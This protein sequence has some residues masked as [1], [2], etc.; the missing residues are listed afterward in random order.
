MYASTYDR[1]TGWML[2]ILGI[3]GMTVGHLGSYAQITTE[4]STVLLVL[5]LVAMLGAR[6]R[7]RTA[8][9]VAFVIGVVCLVWGIYGV[10]ST[11]PWF[12]SSDPL[13]TA[14]RFLLSLWGLYVAVQDVIVWRNT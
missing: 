13:E 4:E 5:G 9:L 1:L 11:N 6:S 8:V 2:F 12:G 10:S 3:I 14:M 7:K